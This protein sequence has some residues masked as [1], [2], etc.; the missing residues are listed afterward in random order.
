MN[1]DCRQKLASYW[2]ASSTEFTAAVREFLHKGGG[3]GISFVDAGA[4][5]SWLDTVSGTS[6][7]QNK[8]NKKEKGKYNL[9]DSL[10][11]GVIT[12]VSEETIDSLLTSKLL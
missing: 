3:G 1:T 2:Y 8:Q 9:C 5:A 10:K 6:P 11:L 4:A 12:V 7:T